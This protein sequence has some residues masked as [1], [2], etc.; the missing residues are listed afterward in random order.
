MNK[1]SVDQVRELL[2]EN[3]KTQPKAKYSNNIILNMLNCVAPSTIFEVEPTRNGFALNRG[4]LVEEIVKAVLGAYVNKS[5]SG[6]A[7][8]NL[9]GIDNNEFGI[10]SKAKKIEVKFATTF[11][12]ASEAQPSTKYVILIAKE[13]AYLIETKNNKGRF[14]NK[15]IENGERLEELSEKLGF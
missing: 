13:G 9:K 11:A 14:T 5:Y 8:I 12:P 2:Q 10:P 7:D 4:T 1:Y 15:S 6:K 3:N